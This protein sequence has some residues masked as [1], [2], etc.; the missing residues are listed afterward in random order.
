MTTENILD[1]MTVEELKNTI[2]EILRC[3][4]ESVANGIHTFVGDVPDEVVVQIK[5]SKVAI[6]VFSMRWD[7][8]STPVVNPVPKATLNWRRI[9]VNQLRLEL[10]SLIGIA[11]EIRRSKF[12]KCLKCGH[13][14][15][16][17]WMHDQQTCQSCSGVI[18]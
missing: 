14:K 13:S 18:Y 4:S 16:P 3:K 12:R 9:P 1:Y 10:I 5:G 15:P 11:Q 2:R 8:P 7:S 6:S 17:E